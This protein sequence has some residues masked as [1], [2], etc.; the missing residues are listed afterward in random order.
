MKARDVDEKVNHSILFNRKDG[1]DASYMSL[2][3]SYDQDSEPLTTASTITSRQT[4]MTTG[5]Y[6]S[7]DNSTYIIAVY[8]IIDAEEPL[9]YDAI[10]FK[11]VYLSVDGSNSEMTETKSKTQP[12]GM[13]SAA[14]QLTRRL[15]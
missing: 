11:E 13:S 12:I 9:T 2:I 4:L 15:L 10:E 5:S 6:I 1:H 14:S 8:T 3:Q 7:P